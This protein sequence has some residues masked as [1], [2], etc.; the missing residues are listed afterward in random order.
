MNVHPTAIVHPRAQ[1]AAE[2]EIGAYSIIGEHVTIGAGTHVGHHSVVS[3]HTRIGRNN[4]IASF[5]SLGGPPQ[6]KKYRGE[7]TALE[8]GDDN[9]IREFCTFNTGTAQ[10]VG[11]TRLGSGNWIMACAPCA[12]ARKAMHHLRE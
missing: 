4:R 12:I 1:L 11:T 5:V 7:P 3:G 9:T 10:D 6:D 2:V 8:I